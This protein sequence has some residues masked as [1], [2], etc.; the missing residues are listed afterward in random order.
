MA[1]PLGVHGGQPGRWRASQRKRSAAPAAMRN[2][3]SMA[4][5]VT[6]SQRCGSPRTMI[7][8]PTTNT[9]Q[10]HAMRNCRSRAIG[11]RQTNAESAQC[12]LVTVRIAS[13]DVAPLV[14]DSG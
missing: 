3:A 10:I 8:S 4:K 12:A 13:P 1:A 5:P 6:R 9:G 7:A 2:A 11:R 14:T